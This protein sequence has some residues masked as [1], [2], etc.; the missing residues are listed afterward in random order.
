MSAGG[1]LPFLIT[2]VNA[3]VNNILLGVA[4][5]L[6][7]TVPM[8]VFMKVAHSSLPLEERY[9]LPP[10]EIVDELTTRADISQELSET[11]KTNLTFVS[12]FAYGASCGAI[13]PLLVS[14]PNATNGAVYGVGVWAASYLGWLPAF[15]ILAS[16]EKHPARRV[17]LM[18]GAHIIWGAALGAAMQRMRNEG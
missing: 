6:A 10:R 17:A 8:T 4:A 14:Q 13:Y 18:I 12:H 1:S 16:A 7:A 15:D 9:E 3:D 2:E 11:E 5:G